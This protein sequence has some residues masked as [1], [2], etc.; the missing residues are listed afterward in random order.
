M[1]FKDLRKRSGMSQKQFSEY[2]DIP[3]PNIQN[4]ELGRRGCTKY[5]LKLMEYKLMKENVI[6]TEP[7]EFC[8]QF[9]FGSA[10]PKIDKFG[11]EIIMASGSYRFPINEQF[12]FCP[13]CGK[14]IK[15]Q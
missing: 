2:F 3:Y 13:I 9:D 4:W 7:C 8:K 14:F 10:S 11:A 6:E 1:I 12:N 15:K 5:L